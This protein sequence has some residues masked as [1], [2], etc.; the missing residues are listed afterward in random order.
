MK[1]LHV[2]F[3]AVLAVGL[4]VILI[5]ESADDASARHRR[6]KRRVSEAPGF[7]EGFSPPE[8]FACFHVHQLGSVTVHDY[9]CGEKGVVGGKVFA[10]SD[11]LRRGDNARDSD[12]V[13]SWKGLAAPAKFSCSTSPS[14]SAATTDVSCT[15][16]LAARK[17][18]RSS[19][20]FRLSD[21]V[22][23]RDDDPP[24]DETDGRD[25][26]F[27]RATKPDRVVC[28]PVKPRPASRP[29]ATKA[30]RSDHVDD[31]DDDEDDD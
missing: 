6:P 28:P 26:Y 25:R 4:A 24:G 10:L 22:S 5:L 17:G 7:R 19:H 8:H 16:T 30:P 27:A 21:M 23:T 9:F 13:D 31:A 15:Y 1:R 18:C 20:T 11:V 14:G 29:P 2:S 3:F 12:V